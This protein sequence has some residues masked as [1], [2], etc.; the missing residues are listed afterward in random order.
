[1][2]TSKL[3]L[4]SFR[5]AAAAVF[6]LSL[7]LF[8]SPLSLYSTTLDVQFFT[9]RGGGGQK[10]AAAATNLDYGHVQINEKL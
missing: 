5:N 2:C 1:M 3:R 8:S 6:S 10:I 9:Q 4:F 7:S